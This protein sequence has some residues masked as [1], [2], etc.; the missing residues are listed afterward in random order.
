MWRLYQYL[1]TALH[2]DRGDEHLGERRVEGELY[3]LSPLRSEAARVVKSSQHPQLEHGVED[4]V[5]EGGRE[6]R[7]EGEEGERG[8]RRERGERG[9]GGGR[10]RERGG[11][12][13]REGERDKVSVHKHQHQEIFPACFFPYKTECVHGRWW[14]KHSAIRLLQSLSKVYRNL[15]TEHCTHQPVE[16]CT[17][18]SCQ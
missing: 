11:R 5:L 6:G 15:Y 17:Q 16:V 10:E 8:G 1:C 12:E 13:G 4:V 9:E 3:H 14:K 18:I 7:E 2:V